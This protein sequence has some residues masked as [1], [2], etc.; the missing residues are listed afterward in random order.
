MMMFALCPGMRCGPPLRI[1]EPATLPQDLADARS[2]YLAFAVRTDAARGRIVMP[3]LLDWYRSDIDPSQA[4]DVDLARQ[5]CQWLPPAAAGPVRALLQQPP[6]T[7]TV[8]FDEGCIGP[9]CDIAVDNATA[10]TVAAASD[11]PGHGPTA[12]AR[13]RAADVGRADCEHDGGAAAMLVLDVMRPPTP[14]VIAYL[15]QRSPVVAAL[16]H[17]LA[18]PP[19]AQRDGTIY[20]RLSDERTRALPSLHAYVEHVLAPLL[21]A[22]AGRATGHS[23]PAVAALV[24]ADCYACQRLYDGAV[25][26]LYERG[27]YARAL[28]LSDRAPLAVGREPAARHGP[29]ALLTLRRGS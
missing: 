12:P 14:D 28:S 25:S 5:V 4:S 29:P 1:F 9:H 8:E 11:A 27:E 18:M 15:E 10:A 7:V 13:G 17:M 19:E 16:L 2:A 23:V 3:R 21:D 22:P 20:R 26:G 24:F 6:D